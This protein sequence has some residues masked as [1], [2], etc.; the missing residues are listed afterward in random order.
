MI[1]ETDTALTL[2]SDALRQEHVCVLLIL[3]LTGNSINIIVH[4]FWMRGRS[5]NMC[6]GPSKYT[7]IKLFL[8]A[9]NLIPNSGL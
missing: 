2:G 3:G 9:N 8:N 4:N 5:S 6:S 1:S 7:V